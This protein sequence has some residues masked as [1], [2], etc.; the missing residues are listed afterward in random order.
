M[1]GRPPGTASL[2][3]GGL[4]SRGGGAA[5]PQLMSR[6]GQ[7]ASV[8][9]ENRPMTAVRAAGYTAAGGNRG[10]FD[11]AGLNQAGRGPAPPLQKRSENSPE[12]MCREMEREVNGLIEES[13]ML[14]LKND[15]GAALEKAKEAGKRE[16]MLCKQREQN[17]LQDQINI[18]LTYSVCFNLA[19][20]YHAS[21]MRGRVSCEPSSA[22]VSRAATTQP[23]TSP[24]L[25]RRT[26][27]GTP[28]H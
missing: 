24:K 15:C 10:V 21:G 14:S 3:G 23:C 17:G 20:Q 26:L 2:R 4:V 7:P 6:M 8:A 11:P 22:L 13:S 9:E 1:M 19:N 16:R 18:D 5:Q 28:R 27:A 12:D 25:A